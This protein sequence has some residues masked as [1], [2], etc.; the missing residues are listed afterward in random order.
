M[1]ALVYMEP[2]KG[3]IARYETGGNGVRKTH[4]ASIDGPVIFTIGAVEK[5]R[6]DPNPDFAYS[7][8]RIAQ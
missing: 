1:V 7:D 6:D 2:S 5:M 4:G 3:Y 8:K